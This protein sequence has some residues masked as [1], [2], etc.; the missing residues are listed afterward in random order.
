M[1]ELRRFYHLSEFKD[2]LSRFCQNWESEKVKKVRPKTLRIHVRG[3]WGKFHLACKM[4][5]QIGKA[6]ENNH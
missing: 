5:M 2:L 1:W 3:D 4:D 6:W